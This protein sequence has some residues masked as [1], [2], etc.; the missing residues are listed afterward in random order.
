MSDLVLGSH[1][2][3]P[4]GSKKRGMARAVEIVEWMRA[5]AQA[6]ERECV[7]A[8][9]PVVAEVFRHQAL[10]YGAVADILRKER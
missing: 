7:A 8:E 5:Y 1:P 4:A 3:F 2:R 9:R 6:R 10:D